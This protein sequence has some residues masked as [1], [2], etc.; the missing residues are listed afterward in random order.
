[1]SSKEAGFDEHLVKPFEVDQIRDILTRL[2]G[3]D[4]NPAASHR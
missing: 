1:M 3:A 4:V 2:D